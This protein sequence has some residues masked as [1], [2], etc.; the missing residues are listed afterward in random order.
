MAF[1]LNPY[2]A[3]LDLSDKD[4]SKLFQ[5]VCKGLKK[6]ADFCN[7][8]REDFDDFCKLMERGFEQTKMMDCLY[9]PTSWTTTGTAKQNRIPET[10]G[11]VNIFETHQ[12]KQ[13]KVQD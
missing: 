5:E 1:I 8:K 9:V 4:D 2:S 3:D 11:M 6:E 10:D 13:E 7:G 12:L